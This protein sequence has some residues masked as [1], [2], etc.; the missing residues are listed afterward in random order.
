MIA[1]GSVAC[2]GPGEPD[3]NRW[4]AAG[5]KS[6]LIDCLFKGAN[7]FWP[8]PQFGTAAKTMLLNG[9]AVLVF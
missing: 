3:F 2:G 4:G 8:A 1:R 5:T 6:L 9:N 7:Y